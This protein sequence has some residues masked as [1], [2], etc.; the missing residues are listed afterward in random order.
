[1]VKKNKFKK[2]LSNSWIK[3]FLIAVLILWITKT[4]LIELTIVRD[5]KME[6]TLFKGDIVVIN[7]LCPGPRMPI[8]LISIPFFG[9]QFP[10][11]TTP[12]YLN[13]I[14]LP[15]LRFNIQNIQRNDILAFNYPLENDPPI[16][17]KT[18]LL[19]RCIGL[20]GDTI[21]IHDK[22]IF[23]N[24]SF[25]PDKPTCK[26][27]YRISSY[28]PLDSTFFNRYKIKEYYYVAKPNIYD[29]YISCATADTIAKNSKI[30]KVQFLKILNMPKFTK[31]FP[32]S[33]NFA[34]SLD[35]FG[36]LIIPQKGNTIK[37]DTKNIYFY[38]DI[39]E[40]YEHNTL[41]IENDTNFIINGIKTKQYQFKY[42]YYF[43]LDDNRDLSKDSR[44]WG[45]LPES[46]II[47]KATII[48]F[49]IDNESNRSLKII[50]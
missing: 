46:H 39:I 49:N 36:T 31:I 40:K 22:K 18:V 26:Y 21:N 15:Y 34:W 48:L 30:K 28:E 2:F 10:F 1:M 19:K 5:Q 8:T 35:Y 11:T 33:P 3:A 25:F 20:P 13:W 32:Y 12:S 27:R 41:S 6:N 24:N 14:E 9:N 45:F 47:G 29:V 7:K 38:K 50:E 43:V 37:L 44:Y 23:I 16:D 42:N 17:K 4:F